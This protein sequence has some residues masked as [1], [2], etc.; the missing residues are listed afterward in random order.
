MK[1][2]KNE[3]SG[4]VFLENQHQRWIMRLFAPCRGRKL[5]YEQKPL[6]ADCNW[7]G[8]RDL[9][10]NGED[11]ATGSR[12]P[13]RNCTNCTRVK[14]SRLRNNRC[15][16][17]KKRKNHIITEQPKQKPKNREK[18]EMVEMYQIQTVSV[19]AHKSRS[20]FF[21]FL[22]KIMKNRKTFDIPSW[23]RYN[24][25]IFIRESIT[26]CRPHE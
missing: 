4:H 20:N 18:T 9:L 12:L 5:R 23:T 24:M 6:D 2:W 8:I 3:E 1:R 11:M 13:R 22:Y 10:S 14:C 15:E 16:C 19:F 25:F 17:N 7:D 21:A 26:I